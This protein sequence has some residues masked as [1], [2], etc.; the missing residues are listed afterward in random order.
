MRADSTARL[1]AA[2]SV[3]SLASC[4]VSCSRSEMRAEASKP[5]PPSIAYI[6]AWGVKG[7]GPGQL[8]DPTCI[9]TD[10][11]GKAYIADAGTSFVHK[12]DT[13]GT[14]LLSFQDPS[15]KQPQSIAVDSGGAIYVADPGSASAFIYL[16]KGTRYRRLGLKAHPNSENIFSI[17]VDDEGLIQILDTDAG[18]ISTYTSRFRLVRSWQPASN[19]PNTTVRPRAVATG[20]DGSLYVADPEGNRIV[21]FTSQGNFMGDA[22]D[23][24][25]DRRVSDE[26]A[27]SSKGVF[28]MDTDGRTLHVWSLDGRPQLDVDLAPELG[29]AK[30]S[31]PAVAI[32]PRKELLVLDAPE[33]RVLRY[34]I[35]F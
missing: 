21:K 15:L 18:R 26:F 6:G 30:R 32:S 16:P 2:M 3:L 11:V 7:N 35:N 25:A 27:V 24:G 10:G 14:P 28:A 9:A 13:D 22:V 8:D 31:A 1:L 12:F 17:A 34:R 23:G 29:Q 5:A 20:P 19:V 33:A 4:L